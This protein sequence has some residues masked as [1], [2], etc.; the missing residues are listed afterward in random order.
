MPGR[1]IRPRDAETSLYQAVK[2]HLERLGYTAKGEICGCDI[3]AL[4]PGEPPFLVITELKMAFTLDLVL[5]GVERSAAA[6]EVWLAVRASR[7]GRD[8][9]RRVHKLCRLL[10]FGLL[11][12]DPVRNTVEILAEPAEYRPRPNVRRRARLIKEHLQRRGD[13]TSGG[14]TR[15]PIMTAYRQRALACARALLDGARQPRTL[16]PIAP[17]AGRIMLR[18]VYG[19]FERVERGSY[20]LTSA[21]R[22][23]LAAHADRRTDADPQVASGPSGSCVAPS[24]VTLS[25]SASVT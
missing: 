18:N 20:A 14:S 24:T 7:H 17:D 2:A 9:D 23:A 8:R 15:K 21:G 5:Q 25:S 11:G 19:W 1:Q 13:P 10:G 6:D 4:K 22:N 3:V 12:V 16:K